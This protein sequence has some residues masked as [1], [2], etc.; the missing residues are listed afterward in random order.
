[1]TIA[2]DKDNVGKKTIK[3]A[4][5]FA[6]SLTP[7]AASANVTRFQLKDADGKYIVLAKKQAWGVSDLN[8]TS[9]RG[10]KFVKVAAA[11]KDKAVTILGLKSVIPMVTGKTYEN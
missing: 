6:G 5:V 8:G 2:I 7:V 11:D 9:N 10:L 1:M 3:G 4:D